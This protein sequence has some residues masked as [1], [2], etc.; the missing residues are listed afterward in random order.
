MA[1]RR[2]KNTGLSRTGRLFHYNPYRLSFYHLYHIYYHGYSTLPGGSHFVYQAV[3]TSL[4]RGPDQRASG[5]ARGTLQNVYREGEETV[6]LCRTI[7][8]EITSVFFNISFTLSIL[9]IHVNIDLYCSHQCRCIT[10]DCFRSLDLS[11]LSC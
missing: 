10:K 9:V 8:F 11:K 4:A 5:Q 3:N 2:V 7:L 6:L 1:A